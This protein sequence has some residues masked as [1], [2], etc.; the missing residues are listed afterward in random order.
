MHSCLFHVPAWAADSTRPWR[1]LTPRPRAARHRRR[2]APPAPPRPQALI[3]GAAEQRR[4][5]LSECCGVATLRPPRL[6]SEWTWAQEMRYGDFLRVL[7]RI[8]G[9]FCGESV[10]KILRVWYSLKKKV[11]KWR[12]KLIDEWLIIVM[13]SDSYLRFFYYVARNILLDNFSKKKILQLPFNCNFFLWYVYHEEGRQSIVR[14]AGDGEHAT[15]CVFFPRVNMD[16]FLYFC[17]LVLRI[18][19]IFLLFSHF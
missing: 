3:Y 10:L 11:W 16:V 7:L 2:A 5:D 13:S 9:H 8:T 19:V 18:C 4:R 15:R 1:L 6:R 17:W 14:L 12:I